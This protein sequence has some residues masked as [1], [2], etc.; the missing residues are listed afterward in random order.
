MRHFS[1]LTH[2]HFCMTKKFLIYTKFPIQWGMTQP[3]VL[4]LFFWNSVLSWYF[5]INYVEATLRSLTCRP[6][7][8]S[9][10]FVICFRPSLAFEAILNTNFRNKSLLKPT[11]LT[12][13]NGWRILV[14]GINCRLCFKKWLIAQKLHT[15]LILWVTDSETRQNFLSNELWHSH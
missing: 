11:V 10:T 4:F 1:K 8:I 2:K 7:W 15:N 5:I 3:L 13:N 14:P 6:Y 12:F 9:Y